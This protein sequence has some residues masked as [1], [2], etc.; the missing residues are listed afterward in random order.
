MDLRPLLHP[1]FRYL[2]EGFKKINLLNIFIRNNECQAKP[3]LEIVHTQI[4]PTKKFRRQHRLKHIPG[5][6]T[7]CN[8]V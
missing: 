3:L 6:A 7:V 1:E 4:Q 8:Q 5:K 2:A